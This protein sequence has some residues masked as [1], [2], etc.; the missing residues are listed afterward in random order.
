MM[1]I[2]AGF[3]RKE[4]LNDSGVERQ[5]TCCCGCVVRISASMKFIRCDRPIHWRNLSDVGVDHYGNRK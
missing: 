4:A 2:F 3:S 1:Q 5:P